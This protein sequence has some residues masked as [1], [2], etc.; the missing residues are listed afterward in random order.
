MHRMMALVCAAVIALASVPLPAS[1]QS[2]AGEIRIAVT[3]A[4]TKSPVELA[5]I[6]LDGPVITTEFSGKNG[7]VRFI[8]VPDGI[9]RARVVK[10]GY[11]SVT[12]AEFEVL[13][14][15]LVSV[16]VALAPDTGTLHVIAT[17]TSRSTATVSSSSLSEDSAQRK[18]SDD[19]AGALNKLSGV[20]V[21]TS[22]DDA[23]A[24][25]TISLEGHDASQTQLSLNGIPLNAPGAA[26]NLRGY[27]TDLFSGASVSFGPQVG[28]LGGGVNFRTLQPTLSWQSITQL[29]TGSNG[30]YNYSFGETGSF[31]KLGIAAQ[32]TYRSTPSLVD[33]M[34]YLDAS[35]LDYVHDGDRTSR[36]ALLMLRYRISDA[37]TITAQYMG[38]QNSSALVCLHESGGLP[39]GYGPGNTNSSSFGLYSLTDT[40]LI[41]DTSV[42]AAAF[43]TTGSFNTDEL[44]RYSN[45]VPAPIGYVSSLR[46]FGY[47]VSAQL[48]AKER[49][50]ISL[51]ANGSTSTNT[52]T[53]TVALAAPFY[54]GSQSS[55]YGSLQVS[56]SI[57][58][59]T[60][61]TLNESFGLSRASN[62]PA[63]ILASVSAYWKPTSVDSY[64]ASYSV[65]GSGGRAGRS[66]ILTDPTSL[67][68]DCNGDT[69]SG[70]APGD[71]P[72]ASSST[73]A[74][75]SYTHAWKGASLSGSL[76]RQSQVDVVLPTLVNGSVLQTLG[77]LPPGY[78]GIVQGIF[79]SPAG[80]N[81]PPSVPFGAQNLYFRTPIGGAVR[82][83]EGASVSGYFTLGNLVAQPY[84]DVSV[85]QAN[86]SDI[87][88]N[89]PYSTTISG[90]QL[91]GQPLHR[92]G[93]T[94]DYKAKGS[95][96]E[97]IADAQYTG[98]NNGNDLPAY[99]TFDAGVQATLK[100]G[101]LTFA[102]SNITNAYAGI[103]ASPLNA[104]PQQT[105]GGFLVPTLASPLAPRSV[106][107]TYNFKTGAAPS[108]SGAPPDLSNGGDGGRGGRGGGR[109]G[110]G[111]FGQPLP[112]TAPADP[113]AVAASQACTSDGQAQA[114]AVLDPI[115]AYVAQ[116]EAAKTPAGYPATVPAPAIP[117][118]TVTY[119][120]LGSTYALSI[121]DK[122]ASR[123]RAVFPCLTLHVATQDDVK[124][125]NL[126]QPPNSVF[127]VP[128][129][130]FMPSVGLYFAQR[131]PQSGQESFRLYK[132]PTTP[133]KA[134]F[135]VIAS[136]RC[137]ADLKGT[138]TQLLGELQKHFATGAPTPSWTITPHVQ[139]SG[140][141]YELS[142]DDVSAIPAI[143][144]CGRVATA[145][146]DDLVA[147]GWD[148]P[149]PTP[150]PG[151]RGGGG[152]R[153]LSY[154]PALGIYLER[155]NPVQGGPAAPT[156]SPSPGPTS[157]PTP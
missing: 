129:I 22:S 118:V 86:S 145:T 152:F 143:L 71:Q 14:G 50:T 146:R 116:I 121:V 97:W 56:D 144:Q 35:G 10:R 135:A 3:D 31:G 9:Y 2:D 85:V 15:K 7:Q 54:N 32:S 27:S 110:F 98:S 63:S 20:S 81:A 90:T 49:H 37:Q 76:Y 42:Q 99:T 55:S 66:S 30:K 26:G 137:T 21:T 46:S 149:A 140:T 69:A 77:V 6:L 126:Y 64:A 100:R 70:S 147:I 157:S 48:P 51:S 59:N 75:L 88:I 139:K 52:T 39:C 132:L 25:Q 122:S 153:G 78:V 5:R 136:D 45:G 134:P 120:G 101:T 13:G 128:S 40:A 16:T 17:V 79:R 142:S 109:G 150:A 60:K 68:F 24:T 58:S 11:S 82:L 111:R 34:R 92:A 18:L 106:S 108:A 53:P 29:S 113:F 33:G 131:P 87:R 125:R 154:A 1:A 93:L 73:S 4:V 61:L 57:R 95:A 96:L 117:N 44:A 103:F 119:H 80:C 84:Y 138:A 23:D 107:F 123:L 36:G 74:R 94:L 127:F 89:N 72:G 65:G 104:V 124:N 38:S 67:R 114:K 91:P 41:G 156:P 62:A 115:K 28:G 112:A 102:M 19:L 155:N 83:Y 141:S 151:A 12:S 47:S 105:A 43:G 8:D 133:P 130:T 148:T